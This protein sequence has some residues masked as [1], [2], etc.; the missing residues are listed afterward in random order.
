MGFRVGKRFG[1]T[2]I[3]IGKSG[4]YISR[5][6]GDLRISHFKPAKRKT[7]DKGTPTNT[8]DYSGVDLSGTA[9]GECLNLCILGV[10][11]YLLFCYLTHDVLAGLLAGFGSYWLISPFILLKY[12]DEEEWSELFIYYIMPLFSFL[13]IPGLTSWLVLL[14]LGWLLT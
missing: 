2:Y 11:V 7:K 9:L 6:V 14:P 8:P 10:G 4:T 5:K 13:T 12:K 3:S 1:K